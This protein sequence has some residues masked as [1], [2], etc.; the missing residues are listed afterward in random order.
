MTSPLQFRLVGLG[1]KLNPT[2]KGSVQYSLLG[3]DMVKVS[4]SAL[5]FVGLSLIDMEDG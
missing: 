5:G 4:R 2:R 1:L 3:C